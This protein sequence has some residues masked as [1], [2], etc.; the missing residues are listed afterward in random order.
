MNNKKMTIEELVEKMHSIKAE[1]LKELPGGGFFCGEL[2]D[3]DEE[4][5]ECCGECELTGEEMISIPLSRFEELFAKAMSLDILKATLRRKG[6][7]NNDIVW[8]VTG[9]DPS[10][11]IKDL[12]DKADTYWGYYSKE[13]EKSERL[14]A[15]VAD[16]KRHIA[17]LMP[18]E[19][20][21]E[22]GGNG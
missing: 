13:K 15:E 3:A 18:D 17:T 2:P 4:K 12:K 22:E 14:E 19:E 21:Q 8:A 7:V 11:P 20:D 6:E 1:D 10:L 5:C 9:A 16:L